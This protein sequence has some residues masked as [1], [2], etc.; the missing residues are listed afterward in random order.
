[1]KKLY[2]MLLVAAL[3]FAGSAVAGA[4][5]GSGQEAD[6][7]GMS[8]SASVEKKLPK[9]F[10]VGLNAEYRL[11]DDLSSFERFT[12]GPSVE[13]RITK[14][15]KASAG[16]IF[17]YVSN[18]GKT[19]YRD[20]GSVKW[21]RESKSTPRYR[22]YVALTGSYSVARF[23]FSLRERYQYTYRP[24]YT[25]TRN[26]FTKDGEYNY[27]E[28]DVRESVSHNL[29]RSRLTA[30]YDIR[31]CPL[32]PYAY[33]ELY[34]SLDDSFKTSKWRYSVGIDWKVNK[35][36]VLSL[37]WLYEDV[38]GEND[39]VNGNSHLIGIGYTFKF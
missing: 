17:M 4:A 15:L 35:K 24:E 33:A 19:N 27:S 26:Y 12:V 8:V 23:K 14:W 1:M 18:E 22:A 29:L 5:T 16:G 32:S 10:T 9:G 31:H 7:V 39:T 34:S 30:S 3:L 38:K 28:D 2:F 37:S 36:N 11:Q 20:D 13:Y 21:I 25:A 6:D